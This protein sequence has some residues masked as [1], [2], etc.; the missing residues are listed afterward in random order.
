MATVGIVS[1][2]GLRGLSPFDG[3]PWGRTGGVA[4]A[5]YGFT[6]KVDMAATSPPDRAALRNH[7]TAT[8]TGTVPADGSGTGSSGGR[9]KMATVGI[10]SPRGLRG[11]SPFDREPWGS[12]GGVAI[13]FYGFTGKVDMAATS[14]PTEQHCGI[15]ARPQL[16]GQSPQAAAVVAAVLAGATWQLSES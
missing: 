14:P 3:E 12:T 9:G 11:L 4:I 6:G 16:R 5:F 15:T 2:R 10:V 1:P 7:C 8:V 13:A